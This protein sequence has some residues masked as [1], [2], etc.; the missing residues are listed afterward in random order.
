MRVTRFRICRPLA[1]LLFGGLALWLTACSNPPTDPYGASVGDTAPPF[2]VTSVAGAPVSLD[3]FD[4][5]PML[6]YFWASWCGTCTF[7]L[8]DIDGV[9]AAQIGSDLVTLTVNVGEE[10]EYV[11]K[12]VRDAVGDYNFV[13]TTDLTLE[14]FRRY[15]ILSFPST[16]FIGRDGVIRRIIMGRVTQETLSA[17][18]DTIL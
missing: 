4:G 8:P 11:E 3:K 5:Q 12:Y 6:V 9:A 13:V 1:A 14:T 18:L 2:N 17:G 7:D 10:P 16:F 15:R